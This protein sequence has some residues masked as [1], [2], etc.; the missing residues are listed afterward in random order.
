MGIRSVKRRCSRDLSRASAEEYLISPHQEKILTCAEGEM[1]RDFEGYQ[2]YIS[3]E[4]A[5]IEGVTIHTSGWYDVKQVEPHPEIENA[6]RVF[7]SEFQ[8]WTDVGVACLKISNCFKI[9]VPKG[10]NKY[11][12]CQVIRRQPNGLFR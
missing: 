3:Q 4:S 2:C 6:A 9:R 10:Q 12:I 11:Y 1:V 7:L 8:K 5:K